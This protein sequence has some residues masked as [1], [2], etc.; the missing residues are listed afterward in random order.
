MQNEEGNVN[1]YCCFGSFVGC[2]GGFPSFFPWFRGRVQAVAMAADCF[3]VCRSI[4]LRSLHGDRRATLVLGRNW[5]ADCGCRIETIAFNGLLHVGCCGSSGRTCVDAS[6]RSKLN[7][8][9]RQDKL[10]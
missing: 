10:G 7:A 2:S 5:Y 4:P 9:V 3:A 6:N 1:L 8:M